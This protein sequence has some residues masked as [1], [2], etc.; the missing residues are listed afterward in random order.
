MDA[1]CDCALGAPRL[2]HQA[3]VDHDQTAKLNVHRIDAEE[4]YRLLDGIVIG[5]AAA[6][7]QRLRLPFSFNLDRD[8]A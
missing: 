6:F 3:N 7:N 1:R 5:D 8:D 4:F 2:A